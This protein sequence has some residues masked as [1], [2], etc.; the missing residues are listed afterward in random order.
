MQNIPANGH[1][2]KVRNCFLPDEGHV[3]VD[4]DLDGAE[5]RI[6]ADLSGDKLLLDSIEVGVDMHSKLASVTYSTLAGE[7]IQISKSRLP[8]FIKGYKFIPNA[9]REK[10][11]ATHFSL[12]YMGSAKRIYTLIGDDVRKLRTKKAKEA[13]LEVYNALASEV[14]Q[15]MAFLNARIQEAK[16]RGYL[17]V[18]KS[19]RI[20]FFDQ[21][22][23]GNAANFLIQ[24]ICAD[25]IKVAMVNMDKWLTET[26]YGRLVLNIHDQLITSCNPKYAECVKEQQEGVLANSLSYFMT[27]IKGASSCKIT[28]EWEK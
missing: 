6:G 11:K 15:L 28:T 8:I 13:C 26:G 4:S 2:A 23:Y 5:I 9:V 10:N 1:G 20:R 17:R 19:G 14:P 7:P 21:N 22:A 25:A 16:T 24:A 18:P 27:R 12:F 3:F